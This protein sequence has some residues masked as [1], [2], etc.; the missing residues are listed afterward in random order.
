MKT[1]LECI[2]CLMRQALRAG[3]IATKD[4]S[5]VKDILDQTGM[6]ISKM[7]LTNTPPQ[8]GDLIYK[9]IN[10]ITGIKDPYYHLK[11]KNINEVL[12]LY[13]KLQQIL[14]KSEDRLLTA[15]RMAIAGNVIDFAIE[16]PFSLNCA[17]K[18]ILEKDFGIFHYSEFKSTLKNSNLIL[19]LGDNAGESVFDKILIEEL[20]KPVIYVVRDKPV[21]NDVT[22]EDA[23]NSGIQDVAKVI[24]S[25]STAPGIIPSMCDGKFHEFYRKADMIIS[26]GQGNYEGLSEE[27]APIFFLLKAKC[28]VIAKDLNV[29]ENDIILKSNKII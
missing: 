2:P 20:G 11:K 7:P 4:E 6:M 29:N 8:T 24:S 26:K 15:I 3:R 27:N 1:Y 28:N 14:E 25:G 16:K 13:P 10:E 21:I 22:V 18:E 19:Y 23:I 5:L 12:T 17:L 9:K